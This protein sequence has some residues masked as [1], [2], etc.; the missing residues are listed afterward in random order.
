MSTLRAVYRHV[1]VT[2]ELAGLPARDSKTEAIHHVVET[3]LQ[4]LKQH[5]A[6]HTL[7]ACGALEVVAEL[8]FLGEVDALRLLLLAK[9]Q[10][11]AYDFRLAVLAVLT[12]S[13][14]ALFNRT[15]VR[16]ALCAFEEQL[17]ALAAAKAAYCVFVPCQVTFS[18]NGQSLSA[19]LSIGLRTL[20][21]PSSRSEISGWWLVASLVPRD[22]TIQIQTKSHLLLG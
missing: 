8:L 21:G 5:L 18:F 14:I 17:H 11:V 19:R 13:K 22:S 6:G 1:T 10:A 20:G 16:E 15:L 4:L 7:G 3:T 12:G 2:H 9:L